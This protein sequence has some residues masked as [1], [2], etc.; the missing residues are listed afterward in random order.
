VG[1]VLAVNVSEKKGT[2]KHNVRR[3]YLE[4]DT[5]IV[6]DAHAGFA[7]RQ[8]SLLSLSSINKMKQLGL[9]VDF[10]SFAENL[11]VEG[12]EVSSLPLAT[13]LKVG[14]AVIEVTQ[15]GKECKN[16]GCAIRR[17]TGKCVMPVEG[18]FAK[19]VVPGWVEVG[20]EIAVIDS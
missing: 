17:Q 11:T 12:L 7:H 15:I 2:V 10:G 14:E 5:G 4:K 9:T 8:V 18:V 16:E 1:T 19:V 3:A 20:D 13:K 6:G